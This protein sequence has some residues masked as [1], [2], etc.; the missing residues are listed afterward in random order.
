MRFTA[1]SV[2]LA[3][4]V[5]AGLL[6]CS[7]PAI[8]S[9]QVSLTFQY[10]GGGA[11]TE[12]AEAWIR[13]FEAAHP[14]IDVEFQPAPDGY[15]DRTI[16]SWAAGVGPDVTEI[17]GDWAQDYA[18]AGV[19]LDLRPFVQRDFTRQDVTDFFPAA[20]QASHLRYRERA[21][22]QFVIPR[23]MITT[24]YYYNIDRFRAAG[25]E[26]PVQLDERGEWTYDTLRS[27]AR[28][29]T[30]RT[31][32]Q[33]TQ[34]GF[35]TDSDS[36]RRLSVWVR[37]FGGDWFDPAE[38]RRFTGDEGPAVAALRFL[39]DMIWQDGTT[40]PEFDREGFEAGTVALMEEGSHAIMARYDRNIGD[41][42][43]WDIAPVPVG[44]NGRKAY[45]GDDGF[46]I[47]RDTPHPDAAWEF[48]KFLT[49]REGQEIA[50][51]YEGLGPVRRSAFP[52]YQQVTGGYNV[53]AVLTNMADAGLPM[54]G[55]MLGD[56]AE[57]GRVLTDILDRTMEL[58]ELSYDQA[59]RENA[60]AIEAL[61]RQ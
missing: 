13:A 20:W 49:S 27:M 1:R 33:T 14:Q 55:L 43:A 52:F 3:L 15:R 54:S 37:A 12:T 2:R 46:A 41:S 60:A 42:F 17:W 61:A 9:E 29:L 36:Y 45:A 56:V 50:A 28:K 51:Q 6:L 48:V 19:L 21:G 53:Q 4:P 47:W 23:Y 31:G 11:R 18:R 39:Q 38:P 34:W 57:I 7:P 44:A 24:V 16:V 40:T 32:N 35:T 25:L 59:I 5:L 22:M 10:R 26:T 8:L 30:V 58:N